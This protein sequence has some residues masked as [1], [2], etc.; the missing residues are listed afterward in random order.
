MHA[1]SASTQLLAHQLQVVWSAVMRASQGGFMRAFEELGLSMTQVKLLFMVEQ[2]PEICLKDLGEYV[3][4]SPAAAS[5]A[6][7]ALVQRGLLERTEDPED[8][9]SRIV[10]LSPQGRETAGRVLQARLAGLQH[11]AEG[12][13]ESERRA[14]TQAL[15]PIVERISE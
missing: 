5:R 9:R 6:V 12:L 8:R 11:F 13:E 7:D 1:T 3:A 14:L 10:R 2:R 15:A 4:L